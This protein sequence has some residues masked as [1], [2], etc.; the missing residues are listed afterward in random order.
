MKVISTLC[1]ISF[2]ALMMGC[3]TAAPLQGDALCTLAPISVTPQ[4]RS[5]LR[6]PL[7]EPR[8]LPAG[9]EDF[10]RDIAAHN[11]KM[12]AHCG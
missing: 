10:L 6:G 9:Y 2:S 1:L 12:A 3:Q 8:D 7:Q 5:F 11:A 4:V